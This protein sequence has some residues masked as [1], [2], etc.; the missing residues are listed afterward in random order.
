MP[1]QYLPIIANINPYTNAA[2]FKKEVSFS[3]QD[4]ITG[5]SITEGYN[6]NGPF[7]TTITAIPLAGGTKFVVPLTTD[8]G[9]GAPFLK[10]HFP[11]GTSSNKMYVTFAV[12]NSRMADGYY[13]Y[14]TGIPATYKTQLKNFIV[15]PISAIQL[16][17]IN[18]P[19]E[20]KIRFTTYGSSTNK[21]AESVTF[22]VAF[23]AVFTP[24]AVSQGA[25]GSVVVS[26]GGVG[27]GTGAATTG[28][29]IALTGFPGATNATTSN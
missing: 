12:K 26:A 10:F 17:N 13:D 5:Q 23:K 4:E 21:P 3:T 14:T 6:V 27:T 2:I 8:T 20:K 18:G 25:A 11:N 22:Y 28:T 24:N 1:T 19:R 15:S 7:N 9:S 29:G 16:F